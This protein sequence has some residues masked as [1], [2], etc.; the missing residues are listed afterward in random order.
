[1]TR[2]ILRDSSVMRHMTG[3][4]TA[5]LEKN[6]G[7]PW[8]CDQCAILDLPS[9][10]KACEKCGL[11]PDRLEKAV[12]KLAPER[13]KIH[14]QGRAKRTTGNCMARQAA[15]KGHLISHGKRHGEHGESFPCSPCSFPSAADARPA[16]RPYGLR[17]AGVVAR[18]LHVARHGWASGPSSR[19]SRLACLASRPGGPKGRSPA[20][21]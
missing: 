19:R 21:L 9:Q 1:M 16:P 4:K 15:T 8:R 12:S 11:E 20:L 10:Y 3:D 18:S 17:P 6:V 14:S 2:S 13:R 5:R 7:E